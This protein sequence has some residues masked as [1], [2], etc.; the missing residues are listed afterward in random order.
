VKS[1]K[2]DDEI[3]LY[4]IG[5]MSMTGTR[6]RFGK[7]EKQWNQSHVGIQW[8]MPQRSNPMKFVTTIIITKTMIVI[9][10]RYSTAVFKTVASAPMYA[11]VK[12]S[13]A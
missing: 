6:T 5:I 4:T 10:E 13:N 1:L 3:S 8:N 9:K 12:L 7:A 11:H 2:K